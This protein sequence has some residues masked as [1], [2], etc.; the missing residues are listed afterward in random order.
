[1][2][3]DHINSRGV[4]E[5]KLFGAIASAAIAGCSLFVDVIPASAQSYSGTSTTIGGTAFHSGSSPAGS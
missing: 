5:V 4:K 1:M 3:K 2:V